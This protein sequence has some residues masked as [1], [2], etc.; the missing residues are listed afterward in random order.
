MLKK[1]KM[2]NLETN[3]FSKVCNKS[4]E[5]TWAILPKQ[6]K[7]IRKSDVKS[8]FLCQKFIVAECLKSIEFVEICGIIKKNRLQKDKV[9]ELLC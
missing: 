4:F 1:Q 3:K 5:K 7:C 8:L 6:T 9:Y 2:S